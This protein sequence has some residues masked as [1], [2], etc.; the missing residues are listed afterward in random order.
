MAKRRPRK[1]TLIERTVAMIKRNPVKT[2]TALFL[3]FG[4]IPG[5][6]AGASYV[7]AAAEPWWFASHDWVREWGAPILKVQNTQAV[8]IDRFLLFQQQNALANAKADP[9]AKTSP[10]VQEKIKN[11]ESQS[12]DTQ[13]RICKATGKDC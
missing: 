10:I 8:G 4:A 12:K 1:L 13:A 7:G 2:A 3:F 9:A 6:I 5:G 11:L